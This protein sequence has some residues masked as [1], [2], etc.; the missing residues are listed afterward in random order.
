MPTDVLIVVPTLGRRPD[1]LRQT[2]TSIREQQVPADIVMV[3]PLGNRGLAAVADEFAT[4]LMDDPGS[5]SAAIE[6][7]V[8]RARTDHVFVTWLN[9]DDLLT[10]GS[11]TLTHDALRANPAA[12]LAYGAC[13]YI[14]DQGRPL[15]TSRAGRWAQLLLPWGPDLVPQPGMLVRRSAWESAGGLDTGLR[16]AFDLDLLLRLKRLGP[17]IDVQEV[18]SRFRWHSSSLTVSDRTASLNESE[19]VKRRYLHPITRRFVWVWEKPVRIATRWFARR[20]T[21]KAKAKT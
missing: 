2:L 1:F 5:L 10:P 11:L 12:V 17:F 8:D 14:D 15:W 18:V 16:F 13:E 20:L 9:D 21:R 7:G 19:V 4:D 6:S 3:G